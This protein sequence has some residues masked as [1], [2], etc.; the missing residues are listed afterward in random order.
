MAD[1]C[2]VCLEALDVDLDGAP[3]EPPS[4]NS[5]AIASSVEPGLSQ[6]QPATAVDADTDPV[7]ARPTRITTVQPEI[8][9][10]IAQIEACG[11]VLHE[12]CLKEWSTKANSCPICRQIFHVV[13]VY[14]KLGGTLLSTFHVEDKKQVAEFDAQQW[15]D[16]NLE[17]EEDGTP[18]PI[19]NLADR[20]HILLLCDG[21]DTPYHTDCIGLGQAVPD[22]AWY[23]MECVDHLGLHQ[24]EVP[25]T[26][27]PQSTRPT[28]GRS[29]RPQARTQARVRR[30]RR[31]A[32]QDGWHGAWGQLARRVWNRLSIEL[33]YQNDDEPEVWEGY[34]RS[35]QIRQREREE[36][37][38]R[39]QQRLNIAIRLGAREVFSEHMPTVPRPPAYSPPQPPQETRE[40]RMAWGDFERAR[41][42]DERNRRKRTRSA[43]AEPEPQPEEPERK[44]K[45]PRTRRM[46]AQ[47]GQPASSSAVAGPS[48]Q[49]TPGNSRVTAGPRLSANEAAPSFLSSLLKEVEMSTPSDE[50][51]IRNLFGPIPGANDPASPAA[52]SPSASGFNSPRATSL[53]PP[54]FHGRP[55]SPPLSLSSHIE[56]IYPKANYS[57]ATRARR[58]SPAMSHESSDSERRGGPENSSP[59]RLVS[60]Q[61]FPGT[62]PDNGN[63]ESRNPDPGVSEL[64]QPLPRRPQSL[65]LS[66]SRD[67]FPVKLPL[68]REMK[69]SISAIV[70]SALSPHWKSSRLTSQQYENINREVS[71][72]LYEE[73]TDPASVDDDARR[74][75]ERIATKEVARAVAELEA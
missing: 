15:L 49:M 11:H 63:S 9:E 47:Q 54:P 7:A 45:R 25:A 21:C 8:H 4:T 62:S 35:Q 39:W 71:R 43:T 36:E 74:S 33:D 70:R 51:S 73:V 32:R 41:D 68:P 57:P 37:Q 18:C 27:S 34:R 17:D 23:C 6:R 50:D 19:C 24:Q 38:R 1:Q 42:S 61:R 13:Q 59:S 20:P 10:N 31:R 66:R 46:P 28:H 53:T 65:A 56:P 12:I 52:S 69:E 67:A 29:I 48:N 72:R 60:K 3:P 58:R 44:L 2:I 30:D 22:G 64:R 40:E 14:D 55:S 5:P 26:A 16:D 75:W